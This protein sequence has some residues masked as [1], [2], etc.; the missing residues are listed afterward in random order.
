[1]PAAAA[2]RS[3]P[4]APLPR[5][6]ASLAYEALLLGALLVAG[7]FP[8]VWLTAGLERFLARPLLQLYL[9][10]LAGCYFVGQWVHLG[11]TLPM[12]S[13]RLALVTQEGEPLT[14]PHGLRRYVFALVGTLALGA[15]FFWALLDRERLFLHDRLAGTRIVSG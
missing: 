14:V 1:M 7:S 13:W 11:R 2:P 5:R 4:L 9:L 12:R 8:W 15:G 3:L 10:A 6:L